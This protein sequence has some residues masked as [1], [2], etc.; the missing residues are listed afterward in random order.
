MPSR[1]RHLRRGFTLIELVMVL[2]VVA[3][4]LAVAAP[5]LGGWRR[6]QR[7]QSAGDE[8]LAVARHGRALAVANAQVHRLYVDPANGTY[9]LMAQQGVEFVNL[10][11][12]MGR[13]F[14]LPEGCAIAMT[15]AATTTGAANLPL[16][17]VEFYP[18][19]RMNP[20][21]NVVITGEN[22]DVY[23]FETPSAVEGLVVAS[24]GNG[25]PR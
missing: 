5:S 21:A 7:L 3:A 1:R 17:C 14:A 19:G 25:V 16:E 4:A 15:A 24:A 23:A 12:G 9:W 11:T 8:F 22:G 13:V 18:T 20:P 6:G 2:V 10:G